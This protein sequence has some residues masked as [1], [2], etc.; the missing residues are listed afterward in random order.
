MYVD[1]QALLSLIAGLIQSAL[2]NYISAI[3]LIYRRRSGLGQ[4][5]SHNVRKASDIPGFHQK[6]LCAI[7]NLGSC[8]SVDHQKVHNYV[9]S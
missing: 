8:E 6:R 7:R 4:M 5:I 9:Y 3:C 2:L 1:T